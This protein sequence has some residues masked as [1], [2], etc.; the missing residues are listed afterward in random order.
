MKKKK[1]S[2]AC[3]NIYIYIYVK[4]LSSRCRDDAERRRG[5]CYVK[6]VKVYLPLFFIRG[7]HSY[8]GRARMFVVI[9]KTLYPTHLGRV[10]LRVLSITLDL[11]PDTRNPTWPDLAISLRILMKNNCHD[12]RIN[13]T[14]SGIFLKCV[15]IIWKSRTF[16]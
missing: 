6:F 12:T 4:L 5:L 10:L 7:S 14:K 1:R 9:R 15:K 11:A 8:V 16:F 3:I 2:E 13:N